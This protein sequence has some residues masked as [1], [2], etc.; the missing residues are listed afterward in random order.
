MADPAYVSIAD[1]YARQIRDGALPSGTKLPSH[2][3][4]AERHGCS[5]LT[6]RKALDLLRDEGL[7]R[8]VRGHGTYVTAAEDAPERPPSFD[9]D[10]DRIRAIANAIRRAR[11]SSELIIYYQIR[12]AELSGIRQSAIEEARDRGL[13]YTEIG[14]QLGLSRSRLDQLPHE[15]P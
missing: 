13:S 12:I 4:L 15:D 10:V 11:L 6:I 7:V 1:E 14:R 3:Q 5:R 8:T 9:N 2:A